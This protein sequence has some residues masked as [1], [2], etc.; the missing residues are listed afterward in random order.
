MSFFKMCMEYVT[1][2]AFAL[3]EPNFR[4]QVISRN[5]QCIDFH[6]NFWPK[7]NSTSYDRGILFGLPKMSLSILLSS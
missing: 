6:H 4:A 5:T 7:R 2:K 3:S 1:E